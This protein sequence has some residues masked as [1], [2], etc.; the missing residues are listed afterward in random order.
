MKYQILFS[1]KNKANI[2][3]LLSAEFTHSMISVKNV[4]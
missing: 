2:M 3:S 4:L 1:R